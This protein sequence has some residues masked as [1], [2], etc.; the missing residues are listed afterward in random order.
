MLKSS[1]CSMS[2]SCPEGS[3]RPPSKA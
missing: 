1:S 3:L 2:S